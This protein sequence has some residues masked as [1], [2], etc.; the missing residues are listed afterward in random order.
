MCGGANVNTVD[1]LKVQREC[2]NCKLCCKVF[3]IPEFNKPA[4]QWCPHCPTK[5][6]KIYESRPE[7]CRQYECVWKRR[8]DFLPEDFRPDRIAVVFNEYLT[9][10]GLPLVGLHESHRGAAAKVVKMLGQVRRRGLG[11]F[12]VHGRQCHALFAP[13]FKT[14]EELEAWQQKMAHV[15]AHHDPLSKMIP[16]R[17]ENCPR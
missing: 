12:V 9:D 10:N 11:V 15:M 8:P 13:F 2:G 14:K 16:N 4:G 1:A 3:R 7:M 6:C 5:G 17:A